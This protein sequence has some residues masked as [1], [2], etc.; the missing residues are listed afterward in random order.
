MFLNSSNKKKKTSNSVKI[1][2]AGKNTEDL[3]RA[4]NS[5]FIASPRKTPNRDYQLS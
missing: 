5:L 4:L 1:Y 3:I 2:D